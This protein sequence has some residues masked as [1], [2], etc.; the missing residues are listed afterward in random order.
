MKRFK[1]ELRFPARP[2]MALTT[3]EFVGEDMEIMWANFK[4]T[5]G[6]YLPK[7]DAFIGYNVDGELLTGK[8]PIQMI[9]GLWVLME[10][11]SK[12]V[13]NVDIKLSDLVLK[14]IEVK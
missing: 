13:K 11:P 2:W 4:D 9:N 5:H 7:L 10:D 14:I 12:I 8:P 6:L 3:S 1:G